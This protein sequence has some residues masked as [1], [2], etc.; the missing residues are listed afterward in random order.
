M[1]VSVNTIVLHMNSIVYVVSLHTH[2]LLLPP[3]RA[4]PG[5]CMA[6]ACVVPT[7]LRGLQLSAL[8]DSISMDEFH[9][10]T[11]WFCFLWRRYSVSIMVFHDVCLSPCRLIACLP[12]KT[13]R[14]STS[15]RL[16]MRMTSCELRQAVMRSRCR[17][18]DA[19]RRINATFLHYTNLHT[20]NLHG[21]RLRTLAFLLS[22]S[23]TIKGRISLL[24]SV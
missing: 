18:V 1:T 15:L 6:S 24:V 9:H 2:T 23:S 11:C 7:T 8:S 21:A 5:P 20:K 3:L 13:W 10:K 22:T 12:T 4:Q 19:Y 17:N 14:K 16:T